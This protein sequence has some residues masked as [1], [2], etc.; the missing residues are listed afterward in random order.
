M[1]VCVAAICEREK[2]I[3]ATADQMLAM[4][5]FSADGLAFKLES[6]LREAQRRYTGRP[7]TLEEFSG[8]ISGAYQWHRKNEAEAR[9]L[10][11]LDLTMEEF[12]HCG[13]D[14]P[15]DVASDLHDK[16]QHL[17]LECQL[18][19]FGF[20]DASTPHI[21]TVAD[22][23]VARYEDNLGFAAIGSGWYRAL[24]SLFSYPYKPSVATLE[25][26]VY[27]I[28]EAKYLSES[29]SIGERSVILI[30]RALSGTGFEGFLPES[31]DE[32]REYWKR[33][34]RPR[35]PA[36]V[37]SAMK[38]ILQRNRQRIVERFPRANS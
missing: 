29:G 5:D 32:I 28:C 1:T 17:E 27:Q 37:N 10:K 15:A 38:D 8:A 33:V 26:T 25:E 13:K 16:I 14:F 3:V 31:I 21:I 6:I 11:V 20:D 24:A 36:D 30:K 34:G 12:R 7:N 23:G 4:P 19:A 2:A 9:Y 22:P 18:L 35:L